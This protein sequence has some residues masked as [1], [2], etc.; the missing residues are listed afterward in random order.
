MEILRIENVKKTYDEKNILSIESLKIKKGTICGYLGR[1]GAGKSTTIKIV[2][3]IELPNQGEVYFLNNKINYNQNDYKRYIGY[4]PDYPAVFEKLTVFEHLN[5]IAYLY[6]MKDEGQIKEAIDKYLEHYEMEEYRNTLIQSLSR[7]NKQKVCI[8]SSVIHQPKLLLYDEPTLGLD[9]LSIKQFKKMLN[10][11]T[12]NG[13]T[14]F[15]SSHSLDI[16]EEIADVVYIIDKGKI[17]RD[18]ISVSEIRNTLNSVEE[19]LVSAVEG[20]EV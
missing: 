4:C 8:I 20:R 10:D 9:P 6:G 18:N 14:V 16:I 12:D 19:Y 17:I 2:M 13:G 15:L 1:N 5:F 3:G 7:G 11:F